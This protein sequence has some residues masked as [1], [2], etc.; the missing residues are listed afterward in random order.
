MLGGL[1]RCRLGQERRGSQE[2][3]Q[4]PHPGGVCSL[5]GRDRRGSGHSACHTF[6]ESRQKKEAVMS[7]HGIPQ[8]PLKM[9]VYPHPL[10]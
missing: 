2:E 6:Q 7:G 8:A 10:L 1:R 9:G 4:G 3:A 5:G